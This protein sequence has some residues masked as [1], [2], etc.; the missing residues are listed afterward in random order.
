MTEIPISARIPPM[1]NKEMDEFIKQEKLEKSVAIRK[2]LYLGLKEWKEERALRLLEKGKITFAKAAALS[3]LGIWEF[4][5]LVK[6]SG[7]TWIRTS[8]ERIKRDIKSALKC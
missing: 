4:I 5:D 7:I 3:G 2:I 1:L 6:R 8:P